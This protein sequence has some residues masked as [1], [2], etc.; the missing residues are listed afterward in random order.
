MHAYHAHMGDL[1][2]IRREQKEAAPVTNPDA[3]A[4]LLDHLKTNMFDPTMCADGAIVIVNGWFCRI[5]ITG[6]NLCSITFTPDKK[7]GNEHVQCK[8]HSCAFWEVADI[9][10]QE[11]SVE[12]IRRSSREKMKLIGGVQAEE[13]PTAWS[14]S[15]E[16]SEE[17]QR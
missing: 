15:T 7:D 17:R 3:I 13:T 6:E 4:G 14:Y 5:R 2:S 9:I 11:T 12:P 1:R 16:K 10:R 8:P